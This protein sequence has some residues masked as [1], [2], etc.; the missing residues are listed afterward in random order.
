MKK[1]F[2]AFAVITGI[3]FMAGCG[4]ATTGA[5]IDR[6]MAEARRDAAKELVRARSEWG[7]NAAWARKDA[8]QVE[9]AADLTSERSQR[10]GITESP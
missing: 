2:I 6:I 8:V 7:D 10:V 5:D 9:T 3:A 4:R 1:P